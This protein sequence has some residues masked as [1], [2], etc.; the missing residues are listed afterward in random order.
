[1]NNSLNRDPVSLTR[2]RKNLDP[3]TRYVLARYC[4]YMER[5]LSKYPRLNM[6]I[7]EIFHWLVGPD[8]LPEFVDGMV[9][10]LGLNE[11][12][13][14]H[15]GMAQNI[16]ERY[17]FANSM[18]RIIE[19]LSPALES[20][21]ANHARKVFQKN[22][23]KLSA[24]VQSDLECKLEDLRGLF[25]LNDL[26]TEAIFLLFSLIT[27]ENLEYFFI[28]H[29]SVTFYGGRHYGAVMLDIDQDDYLDLLSGRLVDLGLVETDGDYATLHYSIVKLL[30][31]PN[32]RDLATEF[33]GRLRPTPMVNPA[34]IVDAA[35]RD[36]MLALLEAEPETSTHILLNGDA[37]TGKTQFAHEIAE[38]LDFSVFEVRYG[39]SHRRGHRASFWACVNMA[40][41]MQD[42]LI[43]ADDAGAVLTGVN[44][45]ILSDE[46]AS[47]KKW[48]NDLLEVPGVRMIWI[49]NDMEIDPS[50][51]RR[52]AFIREFLPF[53]RKTRAA[54]WRSV[55]ECHDCEDKFSD[56]E[57]EELALRYQCSA[58]SIDMAVR[59]AA[60]AYPHSV[61]Q[62]Q[63]AL[64]KT[65]E[66]GLKAITGGP[67]P[68]PR[69]PFS[70][71]CLKDG[72][73]VVEGDLDQMLSDLKRLS[74][75]EQ[76][77]PFSDHG[78]SV[79]LHGPLGSGVLDLA[80]LIAHTVDKEMRVVPTGAL[81]SEG[82][83][84]TFMRITQAFQ[85]AA[86][87]N[88][89]LVLEGIDGLLLGEVADP[90]L[91]E[92][93]AREILRC[94]ECY[95]TTIVLTTRRVEGELLQM[96]A[97]RCDYRISLTY[98]GG[99]QSSALYKNILAPLCSE[100]LD[101]RTERDLRGVRHFGPAV[102]R[103]VHSRI[104][105]AEAGSFSHEFII[106]LLRN[107]SEVRVDG[108]RKG[109]IG[110]R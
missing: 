103:M 8:E 86:S 108:R 92:S 99:E 100:P 35:T 62:F 55:I 91:V 82:I 18:N 60:K 57:I 10:E 53:N 26:E 59:S 38:E 101:Y 68:K 40:S 84:Q 71:E 45:Y 76:N 67:L 19:K 79:F 94:M 51:L 30:Q 56:H 49:T 42:S 14:L 81:W 28:T 29:L 1:M 44:H 50:V 63:W 31:S 34:P 98:A 66:S 24:P 5:L 88:E 104:S 110:F 36:Y 90:S 27:W 37:G 39:E 9:S 12:E 47:D 93:L 95:R 105:R 61:E 89:V 78:V 109:S 80:E 7:L 96:I 58:G 73:N 48:L 70:P 77:S 2:S 33:F 23:D 65:L 46:N 43:I 32:R 85:W 16:L 52:F 54:V 64:R 74:E 87:R 107:L 21:V 22:A 106:S 25:G 15:E 75:S 83:G 41:Q 13:D 3:S 11:W 72:F 20:K 69:L 97:G 102:Y 4:T 6:E 17:D